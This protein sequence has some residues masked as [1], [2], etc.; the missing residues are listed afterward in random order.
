MLLGKSGDMRPTEPASAAPTAVPASPAAPVAPAGPAAPAASTGKYV[1]RFR[2]QG[3]DNTPA[4]PPP[5]EPD[6]WGRPGDR[7]P[8]DGRWRSSNTSRSSSSWSSAR[9]P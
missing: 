5:A 9:R 4:A 2:M 8:Q 1:P 7:P 3:G 6:R